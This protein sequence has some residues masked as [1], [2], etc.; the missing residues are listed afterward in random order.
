MW[1]GHNKCRSLSKDDIR[2][3]QP[4]TEQVLIFACSSA[5]TITNYTKVKEKGEKAKHEKSLGEKIPKLH[6]VEVLSTASRRR[7]S[8]KAGGCC[9]SALRMCSMGTQ[10]RGG[11]EREWK[12]VCQVNKVY[13]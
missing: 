7:V 13:S 2:L 3:L 1:A 6:N 10:V 11:N 9:G 8:G 4:S 5:I 12:V